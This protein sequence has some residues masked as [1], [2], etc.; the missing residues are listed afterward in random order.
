MDTEGLKILLA[1]EP[2]WTVSLNGLEFL[3]LDSSRIS[4]GDSTIQF[5]P[6]SRRITHL[7]WL[8]PNVVR[9][10]G[11]AKF[12]TQSDTITLYPGERLP[13]S[14]GLRRKRRS[15]QIEIGRALCSYF[16][17]R[18]IARE[19]LYSDRQHGIGGQ[20]PRFIV[21]RQAVITVDPDEPAA[22]VNG[23]MRAA[24]LWAPLV[25]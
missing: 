16:G 11:R 21:G 19:T 17:T 15:F 9:I 20:Y 25:R 22:I 13:S 24:L 8:R 4:I 5:G 3:A 6:Y 1:L 2:K 18:K 12:R 10:R 7:E 23:L 14:A